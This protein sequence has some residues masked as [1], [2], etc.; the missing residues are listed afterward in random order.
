MAEPDSA[1]GLARA[2]T[3]VLIHTKPRFVDEGGR[4]A[5]APLHSAFLGVKTED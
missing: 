3:L 1:S 4:L 2:I 5:V